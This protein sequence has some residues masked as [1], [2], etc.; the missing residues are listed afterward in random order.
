MTFGDYRRPEQIAFRRSKDYGTTFE[1]W[2]FSVSP[3]AMDQ[4]REVFDVDV[5]S[6]PE[7]VDTVMC[8][9]YPNYFPLE[10]NETVSQNTV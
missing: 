2:H 7:K 1:P 10:Y 8:Q 3:P 6:G 4:C 5:T 9:Q